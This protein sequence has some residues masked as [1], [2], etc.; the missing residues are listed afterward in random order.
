[1]TLDIPNT[2]RAVVAHLRPPLPPV[3][4]QGDA[5]PRCVRAGPPPPQAQ[6]ASPALPDYLAHTRPADFLHR[7]K[8]Y[9][10]NIKAAL[11]QQTLRADMTNSPRICAYGRVVFPLEA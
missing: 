8:R 4:P 9:S 3:R 2:F 10:T 7:I 1:M 5:A 11:A 6:L